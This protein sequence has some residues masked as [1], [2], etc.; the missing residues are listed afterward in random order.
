MP[1]VFSFS[2]DDSKLET[3]ERAWLFGRVMAG[4]FFAVEFGL[5]PDVIGGPQGL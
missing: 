1:A 2:F 5:V 3:Q 4:R